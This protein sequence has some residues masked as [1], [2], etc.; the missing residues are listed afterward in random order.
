[1][2]SVTPSSGTGFGSKGRKVTKK[3]EEIQRAGRQESEEPTLK[4]LMSND[5]PLLM[6]RAPPK[7]L[8]VGL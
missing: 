5:I 8:N 1:M 3:L 4:P 6:K 2:H 7:C